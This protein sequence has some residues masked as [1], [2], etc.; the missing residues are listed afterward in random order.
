MSVSPRLIKALLR[1][2]APLPLPVSHGVGALLGLALAT[3]PGRVPD[4]ARANI[5]GCF[6][7]LPAPERRRLLRRT[8]IETGKTA[9]EAGALWYGT[10]DRVLGLVRAVHG[11]A[12]VDAARAAGRGVIFA[13]PH[14]GAWELVGLYL[15]HRHGPVT[16]LYRPPREAELE[17]TVRAARERFGARLVPAHAPGIRALYGAL[18]R[19]EAVGI[20]PD[21]E[22][23]RGSG[24]FAPFFGI[25]AKTMVLVPR[26]AARTGAA[27]FVAYAERL[28]YGRG[29]RVHFVP[30]PQTVGAGDP[31]T[32]AAALNRAVEACVAHHPAQ[33]QWTYR[34]FRVRPPGEPR[35]YPRR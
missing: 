23:R 12:A 26:L 27:V 17:S 29:Y 13:A 10:R 33:Y 20:L 1:L 8:L 3:F 24:V 11:E 16:S 31:T 14:L 25:P 32:G 28:P 30:A 15:A 18:E 6:P 4:I 19:G 2:F 5:D 9:T 34:R 22:P 21:Q 7:S 35:F